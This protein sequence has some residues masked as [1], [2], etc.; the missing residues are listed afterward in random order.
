MAP[1]RAEAR[2]DR[3]LGAVLPLLF[4]CACA[5]APPPPSPLAE[6]AVSANL[7]AGAAYRRGDYARARELYERALALD[8][9]LGNAEGEALN[10]LNLA[11]VHQALGEPEAAHERLDAVL[12]ASGAAGGWHAEAA[13]RKAQLHLDAGEPGRAAEWAAR[14][15][16]SCG[17]CRARVAIA[18]LLARVDLARRQPAAALDQAL[19]A[20]Q[21]ASPAEAAAE[22]ANALRIIG[23]ARLALDDPDAALQALHRALEID[24][25][26][27]LA[28]HTRLDR[29]RIQA[30]LDRHRQRRLA[31]P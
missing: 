11:R 14:A 29:A 26:L 30:A 3:L 17:E 31:S 19:H 22:R 20:L 25:A 2:L 13:A 6:E 5:S 10:S 21:L 1:P 9:V 28:E 7:R 27:G 15:E 16:R 23:E 18:N 4:L 24:Q 8:G 12:N